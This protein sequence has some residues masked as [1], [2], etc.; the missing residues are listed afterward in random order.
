MS[1]AKLDAAAEALLTAR[2][3]GKWLTSLPEGARPETDA[4]AY[5]IQ[6]MVAERLGPIG[7]WKV[8]AATPSSEPFRG[9]IQADT[10]FVETRQVPARLLHVIGAEA[11]LAYELGRDLP[12]REQPYSQQE[13]LDA[14]ASIRP[15][16]EILDTRFTALGVADPLSHR[17]DHQNSGA[18][19]LGPACAD[20]RG[21]ASLE[22]PVRLKLDGLLRHE[23]VGGNSAG[24][25][26]RLLV[27]M[28]NIGARSQGG[29][30]A[31]QFIT[32]GSCSGTDWVQPGARVAVEFPGIGSLGIEIA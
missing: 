25:N 26:V 23:G 13:V 29:L 21:I 22:Q 19:A 17:A 20:W 3:T 30:R 8:G 12:V 5:A 31:G 4:E 24:D 7:G 11:E 10:I 14:I 6:D 18:L 32:T 1:K 2:R 16:I 15:A 28:A 9:P 27:W